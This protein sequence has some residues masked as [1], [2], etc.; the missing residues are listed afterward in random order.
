MRLQLFLG[1]LYCSLAGSAIAQ[2]DY[3]NA[4]GLRL[5]DANGITLKHHKNSTTA[6]EGI[7]H[8]AYYGRGLSIT[9][10]YEKNQTVF[11][12]RAF[13]FFYGAGAHIGFYNGG[14]YKVYYSNRTYT[15]TSS[16]VNLGI[17]GI[18]GLEWKVPTIP[19]TVSADIK[20]VIE[21]LHPIYGFLQGGFSIRYTF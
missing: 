1:I 15:Y 21:I 12:D 2:V 20:P 10:L 16:S 3:K 7:L 5:G 8:S 4:I 9:G 17:D 6:L 18:I 13:Q 19:F 14:I 11:G